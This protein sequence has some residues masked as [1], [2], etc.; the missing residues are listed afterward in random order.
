MLVG[1]L[2]IPILSSKYEKKRKIKYEQKRQIRYKEYINTKFQ[3]IDQTINKQRNTLLANFS[4]MQECK[5]IVLN[6]TTRLWERKIEDYDFLTVRLGVGE[7][8]SKIDIQYPEEQFTMQD[9]NLVE[10][11]NYVANK[12]KNIKDAPI[13]MSLAEK[14]IA[15][16][17]G[18]D[19]E[20]VYN[21]IKNIIMQLITFH[22]YRDLKIVCLAKKE[23]QEEWE[24]LKML[25]HVWDDTKQIRF[26]ADDSSDME[27]ISKY[28]EEELQARQNYQDADYKSF[29]PY[30]LII[31]DDY[32][33]IENLK[34]IKKILKAPINRGFSILY[35]TSNLMQ[36]PNECKTFVNLENNV[37]RIFESEMSSNNQQMFHF[38]IDE[39]INFKK[40]SQILANIPIKYTSSNKMSLPNSYTFLQM[41]DVGKIEQL[42][43]LDRWNRND[44]TLSLQAPIGVDNRGGL[45]VLDIHEKFHGPHG[46]I[47]GSTGSGKSEFIITYILS[48][49]VNYHPNDLAFILIDYKGGGLAG[50]FQKNDAKLPHLVGTITNI[51]TVGL[52][53]SLVSIQSELRRRQ[54][55]FNEAR[56]IT[57][58]GTIDIYKYQK[59]Y[60]EG[61]VKKP[62]PH[63]LIICD[64]FAELKQQQPEF[65]EELISVSRI[66]RSLGVHLILATQKPSGIVSDQ[67]RSNSKFAVCLK[68]QDIQDSNDVIKK[69]DAA[70]LK[71]AGQFYLQ[72][73]ND[74]YF[75]LGQSGWAGAQYT[76]S[77]ISTKKVDT[78]IEVISNIGTVIK[79]VDDSIQKTIN[80][81]GEQLTNIVKYMSEI[82]KQEN[83]KPGS[84]WLDSIPETIFVKE[85]RKKYHIEKATNF[86]VSLTIGEYDDPS[87]QRQ[88]PVNINLLKDGNTIIYG[89]AESGKETLLSTIVY[90]AITTYSTD[91]VWLY[92]LDFGSEAL[93][94]YKKEPHVGEVIFI[95]ENEKLARFFDMLQREIKER[96]IIL[97]DYNGDYQLYL[98]TAKNPKPMMVIIINNY[99]TF[100]ENY[101]DDYED[102]VSVLTRE[103]VKYGIM[104]IITASASNDL[105]YRLSQNFK[106]KIA[107]QI[108]K[109]D[110]YYNIFD[111]I[112]KK[113]PSH[114]FGRGLIKIEDETLYEFQTAKICEADEYNEHILKEIENQQ[115]ISTSCAEKIPV[116]P[117][118]V[119]FE[120]IS[121]YISDL[122]K[123][124]IGITKQELKPYLYNLKREFITLVTGKS[125]EDIK[126]CILN[127]VKEISQINDV[128]VDILDIENIKKNKNSNINDEFNKIRM[129][130]DNQ[131]IKEGVCV[132]IGIDK[133]LNELENGDMNFSEMLEKG[134]EAENY[135]FIIAE[136]VTKFK[137]HEYDTWYKENISGD[138]GIWVGNGIDDQYL[139]QTDSMTYKLT[140]NCGRSFGYVINKSVP[141]LIK[142][143]EMKEKSE[144]DE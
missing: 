98:K 141:T 139:I 63:L 12:S 24:Y 56:N 76:P 11:L 120:D 128:K 71:N 97:S 13:T 74:E 6:K 38:N 35:L 107:L 129:Q 32:K 55:I 143:V 91:E 67:I 126:E 4:T 72:V 42:N 138:N 88:G 89:N 140:N 102:V 106:K 20:Q 131:E 84:L 79:K 125:I 14:N 81:K 112:G 48:L 3:L 115:K 18:K 33:R 86:G 49:A 113:R 130:I 111:N 124:P 117:D 41:Y 47:A 142:F 17:I 104:F 62:V 137:N 135:S 82:A 95:S 70:K 105:R 10:I 50:A 66:G 99:E 109:D 92:L 123:L 127:I 94:I 37:G 78:S 100:S 64:E 61:I 119:K 19:D 121:Q 57:D 110:D 122:T 136:N 73:G 2:L 16:I 52:Q 114:I 69:P 75:V 59:L 7:L 118:K 58:E 134:R 28:L 27:E 60:H 116:L 53:R 31:T 90:D 29:A 45:I 40:V 46:L 23:R 133:L 93:K 144:D 34:V 5:E 65:M 87:N 54:V 9:D 25:P 30:Y 108:N 22:S 1:M 44:S 85:V 83:I 68:V 51:D 101:E 8:P 21:Y 132:I 36:L 77:D 96:K 80:S 15:A 26:F 43:I 39:N 103:G